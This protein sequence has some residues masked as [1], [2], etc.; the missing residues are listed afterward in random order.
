MKRNLC[1]GSLIS[2]FFLVLS[3]SNA[4][5]AKD[6][7]YHDHG[8]FLQE[9]TAIHGELLLPP[10]PDFHSS[11]FMNDIQAYYAGKSLTNTPRWEQATKDA[12]LSDEGIG[13]Q[14]SSVVGTE[15]S[16]K[17]T[18]KLYQF[19]LKLRKD[20]GLANYAA[21]NKYKRVRPFVLFGN[22]GQTCDVD[23]EPF[24]KKNGSYPSGHS[25]AGWLMSLVLAEMLPEKA[26]AIVQ[27]GYDYGQSRVICGVH[28]Q[29]DVDAGRVIG[30]AALT[31]VRANKDFQQAFKEVQEELISKIKK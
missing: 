23:A 25:A 6:K 13:S 15:I 28:W 1:V 7:P 19:L 8:S 5:F 4:A 14:F 3:T 26:D 22:F 12:D 24:L 9:G 2:C 20:S 27:R 21:K 10:P 17:N 30:A 18:P 29:S 31:K 16:E 11:T